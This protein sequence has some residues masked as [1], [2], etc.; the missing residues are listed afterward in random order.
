[1]SWLAPTGV[2]LS[3]PVNEFLFP[4]HTG[5]GD[6]TATLGPYPTLYNYMN[7]D[8]I[9]NK[10]EVIMN[11]IKLCDC[12]ECDSASD[13]VINPLTGNEYW[14]CDACWEN[15]DDEVSEIQDALNK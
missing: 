10:T 2:G 13:M 8:G 12:C 4:P 14:T 11:I 5:G 1:M 9:N 3:S 15:P 6:D 7:D